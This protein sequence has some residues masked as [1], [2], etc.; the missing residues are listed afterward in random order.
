MALQLVQMEPVEKSEGCNSKE[1]IVM[2]YYPTIKR[3]P[4]FWLRKPGAST[5]FDWPGWFGFGGLGANCMAPSHYVQGRGCCLDA[6]KATSG[7][8]HCCGMKKKTVTRQHPEK[9]NLWSLACKEI[10]SAP[11]DG[12]GGGGTIRKD[13]GQADSGGS[14]DTGTTDGGISPILLLG[15]GALLLFMMSNKKKKSEAAKDETTPKGR[16]KK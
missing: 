15:G 14:L 11:A 3:R 6:D 5:D 7:K 10:Y 16:K 13:G 9:N 2:I 12:N 8:M 4:P 1:N